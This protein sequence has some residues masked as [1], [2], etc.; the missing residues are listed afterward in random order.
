[1][2]ELFPIPASPN[3]KITAIKFYFA[4]LLLGIILQALFPVWKGQTY[5]R[6]WLMPGPAMSTNALLGDKGKA[7][8]IQP[9][10]EQ[11]FYRGGAFAIG[12]SSKFETR[13]FAWDPPSASSEMVP[14][15]VRWPFQPPTQQNHV[16][17]APVRMLFQLTGLIAVLGLS[18]R[19]WFAVR[20][21]VPTQ[22]VTTAFWISICLGLA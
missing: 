11:I 8:M 15:A 17:L 3:M 14:S 2:A 6:N 5:A 4:C 13:S 18:V 20:Q 12:D 1:M 21:L 19:I 22:F 16:E 9:G 7:A 10:Q